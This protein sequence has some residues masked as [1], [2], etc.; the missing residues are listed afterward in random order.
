MLLLSYAIQVT[1]V[2]CLFSFDTFDDV[3]H[4]YQPMGSDHGCTGAFQVRAAS[5]A[6]CCTP[7]QLEHLAHDCTH[8]DS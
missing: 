5:T 4:Q 2:H 7:P 6:T 8:A 1:I 3:G